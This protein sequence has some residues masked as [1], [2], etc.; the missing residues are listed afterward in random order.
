MSYFKIV[1]YM[2]LL[3]LVVNVALIKEASKDAEM[4]N[5]FASEAP[6]KETFSDIHNQHP[7]EVVI[8]FQMFTIQLKEDAK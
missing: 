5:M 8:P 7:D 6:D 3:T 1:V 2:L 4:L